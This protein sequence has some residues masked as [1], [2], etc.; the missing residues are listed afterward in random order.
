MRRR[1]FL[2]NSAA[3]GLAVCM[4]R[5]ATAKPG[6]IPKRVF[7]KTGERL[8][9][10]GQ[11]GG[12]RCVR[13]MM[14]KRSHYEPTSLVSTTSTRHES[15]GVANRKKSTGRFCRLFEYSFFSQPNH[16]NARA[17]APQ[18]TLTSHSV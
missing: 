12:S 5:P 16:R 6:D 11:A 2:T 15:T 1:T 13:S 10:I 4:D 7:G 9:I 14:L 17:K 3:A 18:R 8:T